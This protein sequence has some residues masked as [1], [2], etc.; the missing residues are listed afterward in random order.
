[1]RLVG[2]TWSSTSTVSSLFQL[3]PDVCGAGVS[4]THVDGEENQ[5]GMTDLLLV[6][7]AWH[8]PWCWTDFAQHLTECG[9]R[10]RAVQLRG[11]DGPRG[12]IWH[13]VHHYVEDVRH[14]LAGFPAPPVLV[15]HSLGGLVVQKHLEGN[16]APAAALMASIPTGGTIG[17]VARLFG[18]HSRAWLKANLLQLKPTPAS[19]DCRTSPTWLS[20]TRWSYCRGRIVC[21]RR[22]LS[23]ARSR[24]GFSQS[25]RCAEPRAPTGLKRRSSP[26]WATT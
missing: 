1:M 2:F 3:P 9:H 13:R 20:S 18:R 25:M 14:A 22:Y 16:F 19:R 7:G 26:A 11:H 15:G 5:S 4:L 24:T 17:A 6:H 10:V 21:S 23:S 8:G 12:R